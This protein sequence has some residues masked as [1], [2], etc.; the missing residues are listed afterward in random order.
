[1][2]HPSRDTHAPER[3]SLYRHVSHRYEPSLLTKILLHVQHEVVEPIPRLFLLTHDDE[4]AVTGGC[5]EVVD[6]SNGRLGLARVE[7]TRTVSGA[8]PVP[9][10]PSPDDVSGSADST[11]TRTVRHECSH[12]LDPSSDTPTSACISIHKRAILVNLGLSE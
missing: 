8:D 5:A 3:T 6:E 7:S 12:A 2:T 4:V 10:P 9:Y 11:R 1:M